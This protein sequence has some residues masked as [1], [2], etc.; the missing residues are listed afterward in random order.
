M[1]HENKTKLIFNTLGIHISTNNH[2][3]SD[4]FKDKDFIGEGDKQRVFVMG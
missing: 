2:H 1:K 3:I 4:M